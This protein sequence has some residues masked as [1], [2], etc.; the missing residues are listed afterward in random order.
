LKKPQEK[1]SVKV[2]SKNLKQFGE[3][4]LN[5]RLSKPLIR[6]QMGFPVQLDKNLF[7]W[8]QESIC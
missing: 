7:P 8:K 5:E 6:F 1:V 2:F 4:S 3:N